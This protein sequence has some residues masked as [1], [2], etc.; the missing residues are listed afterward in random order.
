M[1]H[2][3]E[4]FYLGGGQARQEKRSDP[5]E[6]IGGSSRVV[7][8]R[9][10]VVETVASPLVKEPLP[11]FV[12]ALGFVDR[13]HRD[14]GVARSIKAEYRDAE[15]LEHFGYLIGPVLITRE[16]GRYDDTGADPTS[17]GCQDQCQ[18]SADIKTQSSHNTGDCP[19]HVV[20]LQELKRLIKI[21]QDLA[22]R[23]GVVG[24]QRIVITGV[25]IDRQ[26]GQPAARQP[27]GIVLLGAV[28]P[29]NTGEYQ[30]RREL[31][32]LV[33]PSEIAMAIATADRDVEI[34]VHDRKGAL[35]RQHRHCVPPSA[36]TRREA[37]L[38]NIPAR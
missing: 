33:G 27:A 30:H 9:V 37:S 29:S 11:T 38:A 34:P 2:L 8:G 35:V 18:P 14:Q 31:P 3:S 15:M 28:Q 20:A 17:V 24:K 1:T 16:R 10:V 13:L 5:I 36:G 12:A 23:S 21:G 6:G 7:I 26:T 4:I 25:Y 22:V 19:D 32:G